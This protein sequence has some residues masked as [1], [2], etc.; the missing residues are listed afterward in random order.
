MLRFHTL[1]LVSLFI[2]AILAS[3]VR[4]KQKR[5]FKVPRIQ[6]HNYVPNG[7]AAYRRALFKFGFG[8]IEF[9]PDG[10]VAT[11][12][13]AATTAQFNGSS[14]DGETTA[15]P[16]QND[17]QFLSPVMVGGQMLIMNFDSGS[18]DT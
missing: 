4:L 7:K 11:R 13:A 18:S 1:L 2:S 10:E 3:P 5:S 17:A 14:E 15:A 12:I 6:Q 9:L 8:D 16:T